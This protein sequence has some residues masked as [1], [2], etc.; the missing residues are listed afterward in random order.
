MVIAERTLEILGRPARVLEARSAPAGCPGT[1]PIGWVWGGRPGNSVARGGEAGAARGGSGGRPPLLL[2]HGFNAW[3]DLW[4]PNIEP[5]AAAGRRVVAPDLPLHGKT[6]PPASAA[7]LTV[8]GFVRFLVALLDRL[9]EG[10]V[11]V[12]GHSFGGLLAARLALD[13]PARVRRLVL[14][15]SAGLGLAVPLRTMAAFTSLMVRQRLLGPS[16]ERTRR[17]LLA[18][19][20]YGKPDLDESSLSLIGAGWGDPARR[21]ALARLGLGLLAREAD[22]RRDLGRLAPPTLLVWGANDRLL[23]LG[24]GKR[25]AARLAGKRFVVFDECG[26]M[27]NLECPA[28]FNRT[29]SDFLE[30]ADEAGRGGSPETLGLA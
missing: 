23:P 29:V 9:G 7:D 11:D 10:R 4:R 5:L 28:L 6:P 8:G 26:H 1:R 27:P 19:I 2:V 16:T 13:H 24:V 21:W 22:V 20:C 30:A 25:A 15:S 14:V 3:A 12:V 17:Y 18:Y